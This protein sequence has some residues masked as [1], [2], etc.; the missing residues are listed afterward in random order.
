[1]DIGA[2]VPVFSVTVLA[3][4]LSHGDKR[5]KSWDRDPRLAAVQRLGPLAKG[6]SKL[7]GLGVAARLSA[8][9]SLAIPTI[10]ADQAKVVSVGNLRV[11]GSGKTPV[12]LWLC[13]QLVAQGK[14]CGLCLRGYKG[15]LENGATVLHSDLSARDIGDE[16]VLAMRR[17]ESKGVVIAVGS[18]R[19]RAVREVERAGAQVIVVDDGFSHLRLQRDVDLVLV[20]PEDLDKHTALLPLGPLREP[21]SALGRAHLVAGLTLDWAGRSD[22]PAVLFDVRPVGLVDTQWRLHDLEMLRGR[23]VFLSSGIARPERFE[24]TARIAGFDVVGHQVFADHFGPTPRSAAALVERAARSKAEAIV[25]TEKDLARLGPLGFPCFGLRI[26]M[27][28]S[29]GTDLLYRV[30]FGA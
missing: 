4:M 6:L 8:H 1:V 12:S 30:V 22:A 10:G 21:A 24:Q 29:Q 18:H 13:E 2:R 28:P 11:G 5:G 26:D 20:C 3:I 19:A 15:R 14:R 23:K 7:F 25:W 9:A 16:A 27:A 17:L